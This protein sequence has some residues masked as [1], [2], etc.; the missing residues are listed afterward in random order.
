MNAPGRAPLSAE[1]PADAA[2][3]QAGGAD[4]SQQADSLGQDAQ[5][6]CLGRPA[7]GLEV[8]PR[9]AKTSAPAAASW[10]SK[11]RSLPA[12]P[13]LTLGRFALLLAVLILATFPDVL[14]GGRTFFY[15]DF[16]GFGYPIAFYHRQCFWR[17]E[18]PLWNPLNNCGL[19]FLA[20]WNT[21]VL[22]PGSLI[23][24]L[25]PLPFSL[26]LFCLVHLFLGGL[27][28]YW[29]AH[30]WTGQRLPAAVAGI[31]FAFNGLT[32]DALQWPAVSA[33]LAW[34]PWVV[35]SA[36]RGWQEGGRRLVGA[37][38]VG[39]LQMLAGTPEVI[40]LTWLFVGGL[41]GVSLWRTHDGRGRRVWR[42]LGLGL[43][44]LG[45]SAAQLLPFLGLLAHSHRHSDYATDRWSIPLWG[46]ANLVVPWFRRYRT[47]EG[48]LLQ[49]EQYWISSYYAGV[50]IVVLAVWAVWRGRGWRVWTAAG[51]AGF[52][53]LMALGKPGLLYGAAK[54][55]LPVLGYINFPV[56]FVVCATFGLPILAAFGLAAIL[57]AGQDRSP[58]VTN[59]LLAIGA[60]LA[61]FLAGTVAFA[62]VVPIQTGDGWVSFQSA[63][64]RLA[65]LGAGIGLAAGW[66]HRRSAALR[67]WIG[68]AL[69]IVVW[70]DLSSA[71]S[72]YTMTAPNLLFRTGSFNLEPRPTVGTSRAIVPAEVDWMLQ[73]CTTGDSLTNVF[74]HRVSLMAN[75][76]LLE[77]VPKVD[78]FFPLYLAKERELARRFAS[79]PMSNV[80]GLADFLG[81]S[82]FV[83][84]NEGF[85]WNH[86]VSHLPVATAGQAPC[87]TDA[88]GTLKGLMEA[89][90]DPRAMVFLPREARAQITASGRG[91]AQIISSN[92][93][94]HR[95]ELL[96]RAEE[97][98]LVVL[99]QA[100][101][102]GWRATVDGRPVALWRANH[103]FQALEV[104]AGTRRVVLVYRDR[105]FERGLVVSGLCGLFCAALSWL[106]GARRP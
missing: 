56:K 25:L 55:L 29:L 70:A 92:F 61:V 94:P 96:V 101:H 72:Q 52:G 14:L 88:D 7:Q 60:G 38:G 84:T 71:R 86:R 80:T 78:G 8:V 62:F 11:T 49:P 10:L 106:A 45:L 98:A 1:R 53:L 34:M 77:R 15:R 2:V 66:C 97:A 33:A 12:L 41:W 42:G 36:E 69:L 51:F 59:R 35:A 68:A 91:L 48:V 26:N 28:M 83:S 3:A 47:P 6:T 100:F 16:G 32:L 18:I 87:F 54:W 79:S 63:V 81:I 23:Y 22:Y 95:V 57:N 9:V 67:G 50:G 90:F 31:A 30:R 104:P 13:E 40:L 102:P 20:Q 44:V 39:A 19:P 93:T 37:A 75:M 17:G 27:G 21:L 89:T 46:W 43:L 65:F 82:A 76:N 64:S 4:F 85:R 103:A 5:A 74:L 73:T 24:L 105:L 99:S 58:P